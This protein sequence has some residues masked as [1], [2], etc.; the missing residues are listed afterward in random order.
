[1]STPRRPIPVP[2]TASSGLHRETRTTAD[3]EVEVTVHYEHEGR[4]FSTSMRCRHPHRH[5][6][7]QAELVWI[8]DDCFRAGLLAIQR[9]VRRY[10]A[11]TLPSHSPG[12]VP[13]PLFN[14]AGD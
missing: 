11:G 1:M 3:R 12:M 5:E 10:N 14:H 9:L 13:F 7:R 8:A 6:M 4:F 2:S